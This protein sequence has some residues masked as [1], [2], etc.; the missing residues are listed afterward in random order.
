RLVRRLGWYPGPDLDLPALAA[1]G[2]VE[3][4]VADELVEILRQAHLV[5]VDCRGRLSVHDL[6]RAYA[7]ELATAQDKP[8]DHAAALTSL[9]AYHEATSAS[10]L[11]VYL[12]YEHHPARTGTV[13]FADRASALA[14]LDTERANLVAVA[15][16]AAD[17]GRAEHTARLSRILYRYLDLGAHYD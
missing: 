7:A 6:L 9:L 3:V 13:R 11:D 17:H 16:Y 10:A 1:L 2:Q 12:P 4:A 5:Q 14:W 15:L 8:D